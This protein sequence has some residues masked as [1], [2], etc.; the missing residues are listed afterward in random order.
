[1]ATTKTHKAPNRVASGPAGHKL[2][3]PKQI[4][5][6]RGGRRQVWSHLTLLVGCLIVLFPFVWFVSIAIRP[7]DELFQVWPSSLTLENFGSMLDQVPQMVDYYGDS[8]VVTGA[9]VAATAIVSALAGFAF[10]RLRFPGRD[11]FFWLVVVT[12]FLPPIM[13]IPALYVELFEL[14]LL[15][16]RL[17]LIGVYAAWHLGIGTF[18]MRSVFR[19]IPQELVDCARVDGASTFTIL[20][21]IMIPLSA[22]GLV[23]VSLVTFVWVWGEYTLAFT[24]AGDEVRPMSVGI[25]LFQPHAS[26]PN[27]TFNVAA[28]AGLVMFI[29]AIVI[30]IGFQKWFSKGLMEGALKG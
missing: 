1:M 9:A 19:A 15:D 3:Q 8:V 14:R 29:P 22:G 18:I 24:L 6:Q 28:A 30:Y 13:V 20:R 12:T 7:N 16:T 27:Y 26:D 17:G 23:V 2:S 11:T 21:R 4:H 25:R 10:A 5:S